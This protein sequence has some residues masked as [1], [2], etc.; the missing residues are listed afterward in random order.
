M[1][2]ENEL[3]TTKETEATLTFENERMPHIFKSD[4]SSNSYP[5][6]S[7]WFPPVKDVFYDGFGTMPGVPPLIKW[8]Y[9]ANDMESF[10]V[11]WLSSF[12]PM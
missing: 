4:R 8:G 6:L 12:Y 7:D 10:S 2:L 1:L 3:Q 11:E 5:F 9:L